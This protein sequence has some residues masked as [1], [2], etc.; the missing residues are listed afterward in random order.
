[1]S[2][3]KFSNT[4]AGIVSKELS[5]DREK[6][7]IIAYAVE[8]LLLTVLG[9]IMILFVGYLFGAM[10]PAAVAAVSG[11]I[12]RRLSGGAHAATP[13]KCLVFGSLGYGLIGFLAQESERFLLTTNSYLLPAVSLVVCFFS[14][15]V[16]APVDCP[17]K[18]L[19]TGL[20][21]KL[22]RYSVIYL[23][24]GTLIIFLITNWLFR[25]SIILGLLYQSITLFPIFNRRG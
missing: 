18:P 14:I 23:I 5:Y 8:N 6:E 11:G 21:K 1:M 22:K 13:V 25:M 4:V 7:Q 12:L 20:K 3:S 19:S 16:F 9:F 10:L 17:A 15:I 2:Y 24:V